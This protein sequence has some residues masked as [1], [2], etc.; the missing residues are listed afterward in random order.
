M[1]L[2]RKISYRKVGDIL[3]VKIMDENYN[4]YFRKK[5]RINDKKQM[6]ELKESIKEKGYNFPAG[7]FD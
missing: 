6:N 5:A 3:E 4:P 2:L 1:G 7:W